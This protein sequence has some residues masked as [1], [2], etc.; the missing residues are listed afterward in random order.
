MVRKIDLAKKYVPSGDIVVREIEGEVIIIPITSGVGDLE[1]AL[2][3]LN[4]TG[5]AVWQKL[6]GQNSVADIIEALAGEYDAS[7]EKIRDD[8][9]GLLEELYQKKLI[10]E[11]E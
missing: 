9:L 3:T 1:D 6:D 2:F 10:V 11:M 4:P 8:V 5:L 7:L